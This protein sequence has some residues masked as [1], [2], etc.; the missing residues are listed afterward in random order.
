MSNQTL[1]STFIPVA[2]DPEHKKFVLDLDGIIYDWAF[3]KG[4]ADSIVF[5][6]STPVP[7][8]VEFLEKIIFPSLGKF[9][10]EVLVSDD[11]NSCVHASILP[12]LSPKKRKKFE[13][14]VNLLANSLRKV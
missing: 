12:A 10:F 4:D 9:A 13:A 3:C 11:D 5:P 1:F 14:I 2:G 8:I 7:V 6:P